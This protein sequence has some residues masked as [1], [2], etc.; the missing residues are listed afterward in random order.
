MRLVRGERWHEWALAAKN[1][2]FP[3]FCQACHATAD[4]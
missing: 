3:I 1:L 2:V 4:G